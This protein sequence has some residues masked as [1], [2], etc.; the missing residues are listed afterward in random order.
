MRDSSFF[1]TTR[2]EAR[3]QQFYLWGIMISL[4]TICFFV[5][6]VILKPS[7]FR[8]GHTKDFTFNFSTIDTNQI[9]FIWCL[10]KF[11][12]LSHYSNYRLTHFSKIIFSVTFVG[13][14]ISSAESIDLK[15]DDTSASINASVFLTY[16]N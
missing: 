2:I 10:D 15:F 14:N 11:W 8:F 4:D 3:G 13:T 16:E 9:N 7:N 12:V 5:R 1:R 6:M